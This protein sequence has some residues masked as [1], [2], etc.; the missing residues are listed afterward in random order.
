M[1]HGKHEDLEERLLHRMLFFTDAVFAIV[2]TLLVLELR[3]PEGVEAMTGARLNAMAGHVAVFA[4]SFI[5]LGV[6]WL[7]HLNTTRKLAHF[8]WPTVLANLLF[9]LPVCL[10][11]FASAWF[12][13]NT[14]GEDAWAFY[15]SV[16]IATSAANMLLVAVSC[17]GAGRLIAGGAPPRERFYR[18]V[19]AAAPG[20]AFAIGLVQLAAGYVIA[21]HFCWIFIGPI[22]LL[23]ERVLKPKTA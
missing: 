1:A 23:S 16:L 18:L 22:F 2:M 9:L 19:R 4:M 6:F 5:L 3:P 8:D 7:A 15:C 11:P 17:R 14:A 10:I 13:A 21:A 12:G 20:V